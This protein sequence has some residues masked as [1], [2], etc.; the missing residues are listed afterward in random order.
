M[1]IIPLLQT[2]RRLAATAYR[3]LFEPPSEAKQCEAYFRKILSFMER[4]GGHLARVGFREYF[5]E[6]TSESGFSICINY[7]VEGRRN[8]F[9]P[10]NHFYSVDTSNWKNLA[11]DLAI[12]GDKFEDAAQKTSKAFNNTA[13]DPDVVNLMDEFNQ[14]LA[15]VKENAKKVNAPHHT[16]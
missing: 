15:V 7:Y 10:Q 3:E 11:R 2:V 12:L 6:R 5:N 14:Y 13:R 4:K 8:V 16:P 9:V 1:I